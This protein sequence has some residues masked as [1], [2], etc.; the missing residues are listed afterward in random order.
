MKHRVETDM[1]IL[2]D[3]VRDAI[4]W[5][6]QGKA[7]GYDKLPAELIKLDSDVMNNCF[8]AC[9]TR[10]FTPA[11]GLKTGKGQSLLPF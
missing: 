7:A 2:L 3:E 11:F 4:L 5:L 6:P 8:A 9:V 1:P 10:F